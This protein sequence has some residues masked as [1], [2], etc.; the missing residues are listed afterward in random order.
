[1]AKGKKKNKG[2]SSFF[3][4][5]ATFGSGVILGIMIAPYAREAM[6]KYTPMIDDAIDL[7]SAKASD[8]LERSSDI[9]AQA[10]EQLREQPNQGT[11]K[12]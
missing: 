9:L 12:A 11:K 1:M 5:A 7:F 3:S 6:K 8:V 10:K 4:T 2:G